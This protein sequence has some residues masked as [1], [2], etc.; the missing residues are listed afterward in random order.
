MSIEEIDTPALV[1]SPKYDTLEFAR[2]KNFLSVTTQSGLK[3]GV[4]LGNLLIDSSGVMYKTIRAKKKGNYY[5]FW[6][7]EFFDRFIYIELEVEKV[8]EEFDLSQLKDKVLKI[9]KREKDQ[10]TN[11]GDVKEI[12]KSIEV[13]R[14]HREL[15]E[16]IGTYVHSV[17]GNK[18]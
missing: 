4:M 9:I 10:W 18:G 15:I 6:K 3:T 8:K 2:D 11:Y 7:F 5:P 17:S 12:K 1:F 16:I 14:T 13:T